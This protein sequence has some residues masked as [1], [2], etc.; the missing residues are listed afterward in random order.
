MTP[1]FG[2]RRTRAPKVVL[3]LLVRDEIDTIE[4]V[5]DYH[6]ANGVDHVI[7]TDNGSIDGTREV[8]ER[9]ERAGKLTLIVE[10]DDDYAQSRWVTRMARMAATDHHADWVINGDGDEFFWPAEGDLRSTFA[11]VPEGIATVV[12]WRYNFVARPESG[13]LFARRMRWRMTRS[14]HWDGKPMG[15]KVCH[16]ADPGVVV[17]MGN[18]SVEGLAGGSVDDGRLEIFH[19]PWRTRAQVESKV[20]VGTEAVERNPE[21]GAD[22]VWHWR[23]LL[24]TH[25]SEG[26]LDGV[27]A[28]MCITDERLQE[29]IASGDVVEDPRLIE[30]L[31]R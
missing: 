20:V 24:D 21:F 10:L 19:F 5:L 1:L 26:S 7:A 28:Q 22:I 31:E 13:E 25:R 6:L 9:Y 18:H 4:A 15:P 27:W 23:E 16:R 3:T 17:A 30:F 14:E 29:A 8:L 2:R 11:A 12:A